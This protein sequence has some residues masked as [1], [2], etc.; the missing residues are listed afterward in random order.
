MGIVYGL[1]GGVFGLLALYHLFMLPRP[2]ADRKAVHAAS[3]FDEF[4][5]TFKA[6]FRKDGIVVI[7]LFLLTFRLGESQLLKMAV[8]FLVDKR[9][10]GGLGL[11]TS[12]LGIAYGTVGV[13]A[14]LAG[15]CWAAMS[16]RASA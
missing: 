16:F 9:V 6:F 14:L 7:L 8:P 5:N 11:D 10:E 1:M 13:L 4:F 15:A 3:P 2:A 12:D